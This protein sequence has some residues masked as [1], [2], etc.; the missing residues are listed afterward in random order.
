M[1]G[2]NV[3]KKSIEKMINRQRTK[4]QRTSTAPSYSQH[5]HH[6]HHHHRCIDL[7]QGNTFSS[8]ENG[9]L[10]GTPSCW[11]T[12]L[13]VCVYVSSYSMPAMVTTTTTINDRADLSRIK[14]AET[15]WRL[16]HTDIY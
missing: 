1:G 5:Q 9:R 10:C 8:V 15:F 3:D 14:C 7:K 13:C 4:H 12:A 2:L 16:Q 6:H 11:W